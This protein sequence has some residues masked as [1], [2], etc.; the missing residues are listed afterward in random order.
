MLREAFSCG[1]RLD[2]L[3]LALQAALFASPPIVQ[4]NLIPQSLRT[5]LNDELQG[6]L[7]EQDNAADC[8]KIVDEHLTPSKIWEIVRI[9]ATYD[10]L[11]GVKEEDAGPMSHDILKPYKESLTAIWLPIEAMLLETRVYD[12]DGGEKSKWA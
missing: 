3:G 2:P 5:L 9:A 4:A 6:K 8:K 12:E 10:T 11:E 7:V 1:L